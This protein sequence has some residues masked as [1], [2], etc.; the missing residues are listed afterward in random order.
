MVVIRCVRS[1]VIAV[2]VLLPSACGGAGDTAGDSSV[3]TT[4]VP[5][6]EASADVPQVLAGNEFDVRVDPG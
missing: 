5:T 6:V 2:A 3:G 1:G 4:G